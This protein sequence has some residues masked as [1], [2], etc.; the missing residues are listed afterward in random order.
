M[1]RTEVFVENIFVK[2][3]HLRR[4]TETAIVFWLLKTYLI[5]L[6]NEGKSLGSDSSAGKNSGIGFI[7][8]D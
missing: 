2:G 7:E 5:S 8:A 4:L 6:R 3:K 1:K